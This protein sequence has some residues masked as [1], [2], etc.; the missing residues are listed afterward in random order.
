MHYTTFQQRCISSKQEFRLWFI[1]SASQLKY[2]EEICIRI[3]HCKISSL[4]HV[5][6]Y[7]PER[8]LSFHIQTYCR[9]SANKSNMSNTNMSWGLEVPFRKINPCLYF[10][11]IIECFG[12]TDW[13]QSSYFI[14]R[15]VGRGTAAHWWKDCQHARQFLCMKH[16]S[17]GGKM[18]V[19]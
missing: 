11:I 4:Q 8:L 2:I 3:S 19:T 9:F 10:S 16:R 17:N 14:K 1:P 12:H 6:H 7:D 18:C 5:R 13:I 15:D